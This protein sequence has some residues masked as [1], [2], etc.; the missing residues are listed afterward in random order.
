M[1]PADFHFLRPAWFLALLPLALLLAYLA[2][3]GLARSNWEAV[4][5][6]HL[7]PFILMGRAVA[8]RRRSLA[9]IAA[10]GVLA[11][12]ALAGPAWE[13]LPQPVFRDQSAFVIAL[14]LSRSM[15][16][17]DIE[18]SRLSRARFKMT[19]LLSQRKSGQTALVV[20]ANQAFVVV[21]L[22]DDRN[23]I[24]LYLQ[25]LTTD[26]LPAQGSRPDRALQE[27]GALLQQAGVPAGDIL[28]VT[29]Y[30]DARAAA[31]ARHLA[32]KNYR[33]SVLG[34]GT[35]GGAPVPTKSGDFLT[36]GG[37]IVVPALAGDAL[38]EVAQAGGGI[39]RRLGLAGSAD[40]SDLAAWAQTSPAAK[41][42]DS[43]QA[44]TE[45]WRERGPWLLL[46]LAPLAALAF[47]RG[48]LAATAALLLLPLPQA[49]HAQSWPDAWLRPDQQAARALEGGD[50][51][52][53]ARLF[54]DARW[55]AAAQYRN[56][57]Y[58]D[59]A[60]TLEPFAGAGDWYNRGNA[61]AHAGDLQQA[62]A[63]YR[64]ALELAPDNADARHNLNL[65]EQVMQQMQQQMQQ[66][67]EGE[68][69]QAQQQEGDG[70]D[71][72]RRA[73]QQRAGADN[74]ESEGGD[75]QDAAGDSDDAQGDN[76]AAAGADDS[77]TQAM[78][79]DEQAIE[80]YLRRISDDPRRLLQRKL[81]HLNRR[82]ERAS[83]ERGGESPW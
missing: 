81:H 3:G 14:D 29:D 47:R 73:Q 19:D 75:E 68:Q 51:A 82:K 50:A 71:Q 46:L 72:A 45:V 24:E 32:G 20:Y 26:L 77:A 30:A 79:E 54:E 35:A 55:R 43:E 58:A 16:A 62:V 64:R 53:A 34:V 18:P 22:T 33:V 31:E 4:C 39:Y 60:K 2:R 10:A 15:D 6:R 52:R 36:H 11:L 70:E 23:A 41:A 25:S 61:L 80:Q 67:G 83:G 44:A 59:A 69:Q 65:V 38:R 66:G 13:R 12:T 49:G 27:A 9:L 76:A 63:A 57:D 5:D 48:V 56:G 1:F 42:E 17:T 78:T 37:E 28:L 7:L 8:G 21:P 40:V 74:D